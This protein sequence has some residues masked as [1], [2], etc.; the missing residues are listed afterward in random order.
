MTQ[1][2]I[3]NFQYH[4][5][6]VNDLEKSSDY[7]EKVFGIEK[8]LHVDENL[9]GRSVTEV[10]YK[11]RGASPALPFMLVKFHDATHPVVGEVV[12]TYVT[13]DLAALLDRVRAAGGTI[14]QDIRTREEHGVATA[15]VRDLEGHFMEIIH[16]LE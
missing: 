13:D 2:D 3:N 7:Y 6:I 12:L 10:V 16:P 11:G 15:F 14:V 4:K 8:L 1:H 5:L 9:G